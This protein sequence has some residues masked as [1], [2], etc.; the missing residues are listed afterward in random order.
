MIKELIEQN[1]VFLKDTPEV[2]FSPGRVNLI[3]EHIDYHGGNVFPAA[4]ELGIYAFVTKR[5]D[6]QFKVKSL[7]MNDSPIMIQM[8]DL[9]YAK[10]RGWANFISG[11]MAACLDTIPSHGLNIVFYSNLPSSSGLSS[12]AALEV[13]VGVILNQTYALGIP[14]KQ[15]VQIAQDVENNY[16]HV[17]CGI[18]DQFAVGMGKKDHAIFLNT[19]TLDY[20]LVPFVLKEYKL[21]IANTNKSRQ[22]ADSKYNERVNECRAALEIIQKDY[23]DVPYLSA[24]ELTDLE[25]V[26]HVLKDDL[27]F[28]RVRHVVTET[29]RTNQAVDLLK[30][31]NIKS[32]GELLNQSHMSLKNDYEVSCHELDVLVDAFLKEGAIGARMTGAGFG[33]CIVAIVKTSFNVA[34]E[35]QI[36]NIYTSKIHL[37]TDIYQANPSDGTK[38]IN[39]E[40]LL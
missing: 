8:N 28:R 16:I 14:R 6:Q 27:L 15:L 2:Y 11:M 22:L 3:G 31:G 5:N 24:L 20:E 32:F 7:Q 39:I 34:N 19:D 40:E 17:K 21:M 1:K 18:M 26:E 9:A 38:K 23:K 10:K 33:G 37:H 30:K 36:Q 4:I 25:A 12:S 13:L 35:Q 29:K